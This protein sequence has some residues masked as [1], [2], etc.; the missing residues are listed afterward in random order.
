MEQLRLK[1]KNEMNNKALK[2]I[3]RVLKDHNREKCTMT[4]MMDTKKEIQFKP[5]SIADPSYR[6]I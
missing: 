6:L 5:L 3:S 4:D 1:V 2:I